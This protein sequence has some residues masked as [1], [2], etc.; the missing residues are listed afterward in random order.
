[1]A[2]I[3]DLE[4]WVRAYLRAYRWRRIEPVPLARLAKPLASC[5]VALVTTAGLVPDGQP[6][7]DRSV[8]GGDFSFRVIDGGVEVASLVDFHRSGSFDHAGV[9]ADR[10]LAFPLDRLRELAAE[11]RVGSVAPR[12]LSFMGSITAPGR[13][14][15]QSAPRGVELLVE[16]Q[17]DVALLVPV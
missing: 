14:V 9:A 12:H 6:P 11:G 7:F 17:V 3:D 13:L 5:R 4:L 8:R 16:D 10:N 1:M 2:A 15:K